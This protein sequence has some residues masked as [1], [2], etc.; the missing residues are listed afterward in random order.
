MGFVSASRGNLEPASEHLLSEVAIVAGLAQ[1]VLP[2]SAVDWKAWTAD[3][4][5][6]RAKVEEVVPGFAPYEQRLRGGGFN[7]PHAVR[8]HLRFDTPSGKAEFTVHAIPDLSL[9]EGALRLMTLRSHDQFNTTIYGLNDR[10]RGVAKGRR[11]IFLNEADLDRRGLLPGQRV[12]ITSHFQ[13]ENRVAE[14]FLTVPY[15]IPEGCAA[16]YFP[17]ANVLVPIGSVAARSNTPAFKS[18][19]VTLAP[20]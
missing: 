9:P 3:Y 5:R 10:Y 19:V 15:D 17:E 14:G 2:P 20:G 11:V 7:L 18:I 12:D 8:D 6:I 4:A 16:A 1:A 13:D